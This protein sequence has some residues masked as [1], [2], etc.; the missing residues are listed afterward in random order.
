[1]NKRKITSKKYKQNFFEQ[2]LKRMYHTK[3]AKRFRYYMK[4][5]YR[6]F[7]IKNIY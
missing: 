1:M 6:S 7:G 4:K 3:H 2:E 5:L